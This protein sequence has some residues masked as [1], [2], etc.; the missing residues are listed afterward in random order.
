MQ[1]VR[2][3]LSILL[4]TF[5]CFGQTDPPKSSLERTLDSLFAVQQ[6]RE[7]L[8]SPDGTEVAWVEQAKSGG[9]VSASEMAI[10]VAP[11]DG[12]NQRRIT[13]GGAGSGCTEGN[14]A[15]SP[16]GAKLAFLSDCRRHG[17]SQLYIISASGGTANKLTE[18]TGFLDSPHWSPDGKE[19][20]ILFTKDAP[21]A[22]GPT[23]AM[24]P[25]SGVVGETVL[26][27][28]IATVNVASGRVREITPADTYVYEFDWS[29]DSR[30]IAYTAAK[31]AGDN[32]W[33]VAELFTIAAAG[34]EPRPVWKPALQIATPRWSPDGSEIAFLEGLMSDE[35]VT[36][37][38]VFVI[39]A[40][41]GK[42]R[43]LTQQR[44]SSP[45]WLQWLKSGKILMNDRIDGG[46]AIS[47]LDPKTSVAEMLWKGDETI[48]ATNEA[49]S[50]SVANDEKTT[51]LIRTSFDKAPEVWAGRIGEWKQ[52]TKGNGE[53]HPFWGESKSVH[54]K[55][56]DF[57]VQGWLLYPRNYDPAKRYPMVVVVHGG[58]SYAE[59]PAWP[60]AHFGI[61]AMSAEG[62]FVFFPNPR[63]GFGSG[64]EFT[65]A[66]VK[67]FGYGDL[68]DILSGVDEVIRTLPVDDKRVGIAGWSYGGYMT[69]WAVTQTNRFRAAVAGAGI[70]NWQ[71]YYGQNA[72]DQWMIPFFGAS[73]YDDP[74]VY[75]KSSPI[76]FI[77]S[78]KTPTLVLVGEHDGECPAPQSYEF[79]HALKTQGTKT[80]LVVYPGEG[81]RFH[82]S[83]HMRDLMQRTLEWFGTYLRG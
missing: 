20:A 19:I 16:D 77:K 38:E 49:L 34:G 81:H 24:T 58:P 51:A 62:Y 11:R 14:I 6:F 17:Q 36:G 79:W 23:E 33:Y 78:V 39:A 66:N 12:A 5:P 30:R 63:G 32:N 56:G 18:L 13:A 3:L 80:Q 9:T 15:W 31:G 27:Q 1:T 73:V 7:A 26:E 65:R 83:V 60:A 64:E 40:A 28:R 54:W 2:R 50:V 48:S 4:L 61:A 52:I 10:M 25:D 42:P 53:L 29:P 35:G 45:G 46:Q 75:A 8:I 76:T 70:S 74:S 68:R 21:R 47:L 57:A 71:S 72:I 22:A 69:M 44:K 82:D 55:S 43:N 41:G 67:D 59:S 37:G